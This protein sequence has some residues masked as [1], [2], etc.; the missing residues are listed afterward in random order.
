[1][2]T[3]TFVTYLEDL[4]VSA[5]NLNNF[6]NLDVECIFFGNQENCIK[7]WKQRKQNGLVGKTFCLPLSLADLPDNKFRE[8]LQQIISESGMY[9]SKDFISTDDLIFNW[10]LPFFLKRSAEINPFN[11]SH[12]CWL[13]SQVLANLTS[14]GL[15]KINE[16]WVQ[17][18]ISTQGLRLIQTGNITDEDLYLDARKFYDINWSIIDTSV[19]GGN[20]QDINTVYERL[21]R[22]KAYLLKIKKIVLC[23]DILAR[24]SYFFKELFDIVNTAPGP[25]E[26]TQP[27]QLNSNRV[28][29]FCQERFNIED[30]I[31]SGRKCRE[32]ENHSGA[33]EILGKLADVLIEDKVVLTKEQ[34]YALFYELAIS[35]YYARYELYKKYTTWFKDYLKKNDYKVEGVFNMNLNF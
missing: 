2:A 7:V 22:Q 4:S 35:S 13:S 31:S 34:T 11:T 26:V 30:M 29:I 28:D 21:E 8:D 20:C 12:F 24:V 10:S 18:G 25:N 9:G 17:N 1:M 15:P 14:E 5:D 6:L 23:R 3:T 16:S 32:Q 33:T 27:W 19:L